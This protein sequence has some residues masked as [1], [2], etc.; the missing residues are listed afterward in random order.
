MEE[1]HDTLDSVLTITSY[2]DLHQL[3]EVLQDLCATA[4]DEHEGVTSLCFFQDIVELLLGDDLLWGIGMLAV[5]ATNGTRD[6]E[7]SR[8]FLEWT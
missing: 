5:D 3:R 1:F 4:S 8:L 7:I 6:Q 2:E